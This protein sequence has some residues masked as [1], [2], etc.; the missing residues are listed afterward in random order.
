MANDSGVDLLDSGQDRGIVQAAKTLAAL[1]ALGCAVAAATLLSL[2]NTY[3]R[4]V[5]W[6]WL[7]NGGLCECHRAAAS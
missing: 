5:G 1:S 7:I 4:H 3:L 6:G 2:D